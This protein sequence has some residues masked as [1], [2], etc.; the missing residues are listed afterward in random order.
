[1]YE[2]EITAQSIARNIQEMEAK[3]NGVMNARTTIRIEPGEFKMPEPLDI[4]EEEEKE[5]PP[6]DL[7][8]FDPKDLDI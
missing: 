6:E 1:M 3:L 7:Q 4:K 8:Y 2:R 5:T